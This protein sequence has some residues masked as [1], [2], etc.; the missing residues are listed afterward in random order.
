MKKLSIQI[1]FLLVSYF[2]SGHAGKIVQCIANWQIDAAPYTQ[3]LQANGYDAKVVVT[4]IQD[5]DSDLLIR[6]GSF[7][8]LLRKCGLDFSFH[9]SIPEDVKKIIFFNI[10][11]RTT[12]RRDLSRFP[13]EKLILFMWEPKTVL[14]DMYLQKIQDCFSKIYTWDDSLVDGKLYFKF[15]YPAYAQRLNQIPS[16]GEKKL[17]TLV[18]SNLTSNFEYEL[19][20]ER[21]A[22]IHYFESVHE[23]GFEF[24]GRGWNVATTP[25]YRGAINDKLETIKNYRF[26]I[27]YENT[28]KSSG[29]VTEKIFDCFA[30]GTV[31]IY[32]GPDNIEEYVPKEAFISRSDF[33]SLEELHLFIKSMPQ[34]VYE[35]YLIQA[36]AFLESDAAKKFTWERFAQDFYQSILY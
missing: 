19:Y 6:N 28:A 25:S 8:K 1:F 4:N 13:K 34:D 7:Y 5:Y 15:H 29:Y 11:S 22:A 33:L 23:E 35:G 36:Q 21:R 14:P 30:A 2:H 3:I 18:A 27:C 9:A 24:Y 17:C 32:W 10:D 26:S 12:K 20:S 16:F 31:P